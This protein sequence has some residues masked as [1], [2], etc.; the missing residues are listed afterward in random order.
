ME[1]YKT[2]EII[3]VK[4]GNKIKILNQ[5]GQYTKWANKTWTINH[6]AYSEEQHPGYDNGINIPGKR[7][8]PLIDCKDLPVS[9]YPWEY[10]I[11]G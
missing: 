5:D 10:E 9:L 6:I 3:M 2:G 7:K 11:V 1:H 8:H 4:I